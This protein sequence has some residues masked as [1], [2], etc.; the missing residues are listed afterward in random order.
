MSTK[1]CP[2]CGGSGT[3]PDYSSAPTR[4]SNVRVS[5]SNK[6]CS[7]CGGRGVVGSGQRSSGGCAIFL[8][9]TLLLLSGTLFALMA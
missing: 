9:P 5:Y 7:M 2:G 8:V 1:T 3:V 6:T 4:E